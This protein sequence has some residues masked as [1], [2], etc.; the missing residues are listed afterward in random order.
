MLF[1]EP[2]N[3]TK[4]LTYPPEIKAKQRHLTLSTDILEN[5]NELNTVFN[6][7]NP[8]I[9]LNTNLLATIIFKKFF[10][11]FETLTDTEKLEFI[12]NE[13]LKELF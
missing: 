5:I 8:Q 7:K 1:K 10:K 11:E 6:K 13:V 2:E 3:Q 9:K 4:Y 12:K